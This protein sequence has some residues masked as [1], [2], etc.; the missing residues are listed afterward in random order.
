MKLQ[1]EKVQLQV[2][3][4]YLIQL[5]RFINNNINK[6]KKK[7]KKIRKNNTIILKKTQKIYKMINKKTL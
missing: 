4:I 2:Y 5:T 7:R 1:C 3:E 6:I